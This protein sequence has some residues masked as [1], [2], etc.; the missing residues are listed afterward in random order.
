[1]EFRRVRFRSALAA[2]EAA[3]A[4]AHGVQVGG[5]RRGAPQHEKEREEREAAGM[6]PDGLAP[7][8]LPPQRLPPQTLQEAVVSVVPH[9]P[10]SASCRPHTAGKA[11]PGCGPAWSAYLNTTAKRGFP[12]LAPATTVAP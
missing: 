10:S 5:R 6:P 7:Q 9:R 1:M 12:S 8:G 11:I 3:L 2:P 4:V